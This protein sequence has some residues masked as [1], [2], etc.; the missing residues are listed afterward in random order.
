MAQWKIVEL[1]TEGYFIQKT[2]KLKQCTKTVK[3]MNQSM[4]KKTLKKQRENIKEM[5]I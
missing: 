1:G 2:E 5:I 3:V 4:K